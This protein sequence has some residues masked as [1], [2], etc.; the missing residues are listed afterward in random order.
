MKRRGKTKD[1]TMMEF[2]KFSRMVAIIL[3][4]IQYIT[5]LQP[6]T[7]SFPTTTLAIYLVKHCSVTGINERDETSLSYWLLAVNHALLKG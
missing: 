6:V 4:D 2:S 1:K 5:N 3:S 7:T